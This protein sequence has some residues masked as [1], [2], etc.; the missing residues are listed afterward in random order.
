M[1]RR[2]SLERRT[3]TKL[4]A[5]AFLLLATLLS[6][7]RTSSAACTPSC[8]SSCGQRFNTCINNGLP[9]SACQVAY[10]GCMARCG[11]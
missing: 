1:N 4:A 9:L 11:C 2:L 6:S 3:L 7:P 5:T 10:N 8:Q